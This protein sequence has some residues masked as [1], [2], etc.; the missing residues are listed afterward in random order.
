MPGTGLNDQST[1]YLKKD[2]FYDDSGCYTFEIEITN[3]YYVGDTASVYTS[4]NSWELDWNED[5]STQ[6]GQM[7]TC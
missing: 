4:S 2:D 5:D 7:T 1:E 6:D 3:Q